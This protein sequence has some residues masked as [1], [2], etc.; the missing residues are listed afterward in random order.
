MGLTV[1]DTGRPKPPALSCCAPS[2]DS[3]TTSPCPVSATQ[4]EPSRAST[5]TA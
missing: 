1:I 2:L 3:F 4:Q 5:D